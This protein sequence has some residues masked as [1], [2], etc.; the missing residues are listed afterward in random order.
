MGQLLEDLW[1]LWY[2]IG[3]HSDSRKELGL[4]RH[5]KLLPGYFVAPELSSAAL[6]LLK[7]VLFPH[8]QTSLL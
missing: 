2:C 8:C 4:G 5:D 3:V 1:M 7:G 6:S